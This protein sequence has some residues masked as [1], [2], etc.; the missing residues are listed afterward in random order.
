MAATRPTLTHCSQCDDVTAHFDG[1]CTQC[2]HAASLV[3]G[4]RDEAEHEAA[5]LAADK[6]LRANGHRRAVRVDMNGVFRWSCQCGRGETGF[7]FRA[8]AED[9]WREAHG[10]DPIIGLMG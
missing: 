3:P 5:V 9:D 7:P 1:T 2:G 10:L 8:Y 6:H 4:T